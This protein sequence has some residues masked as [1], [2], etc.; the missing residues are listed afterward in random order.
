MTMTAAVLY[1]SV[2]CPQRVARLELWNSETLGRGEP[3]FNPEMVRK[4][5]P[6]ILYRTTG[7]PLQTERQYRWLMWPF[8]PRLGSRPAGD[9]AT[10][11]LRW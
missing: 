8:L 1:D 11:G 4:Q 7:L 6:D 5:K 3:S 2:Q 10:V 9:S